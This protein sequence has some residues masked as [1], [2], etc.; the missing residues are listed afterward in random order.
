M[1]ILNSQQIPDIVDSK[2]FEIFMMTHRQ[3]PLSYTQLFQTKTV[4]RGHVDTLRF[5]GV[6]RFLTK[7]EGTPVQYDVPVQGQSTRTTISTFALGVQ[8]TM[9]AQMDAQFDVLDRQVEGLTRSRID[10]EERLNWGLIGDMFD[11][12]STGIGLDGLSI[13]NTAHTLL[14]PPTAALATQ[15][16]ELSPGAP[17]D[18]D[19]LEAMLIIGETQLSEEG[20]QVGK[21]L[22]FRYLVVPSSLMHI[23]WT[24]LNTTGRPGGDLNDANTL[25]KYNMVPVS[26]PYLNDIDTSDFSIMAEKGQNGL[27]YLS[28][29]RATMSRSVDADTGNRKLRQMYRGNTQHTSPLGLGIVGSQV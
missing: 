6:G 26:S 13:V 12:S 28:R 3:N 4:T 14:K 9:E 7:N 5:S 2:P 24:L 20:H 22:R 18:I 27:T 15:S 1:A 21:S 17:L 25:T 16:N 8:M 10:H 19:S 29:M 11:G 23:A